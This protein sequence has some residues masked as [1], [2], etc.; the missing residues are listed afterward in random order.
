MIETRW[1][2]FGQELETALTGTKVHIGRQD[3]A[4]FR[5]ERLA[6]EE[7]R[8]RELE[9]VLADLHA[10]LGAERER[11]SA[12][13]ALRDAEDE[14]RQTANLICLLQTNEKMV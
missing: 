4:A 3:R 14:P 7:T 13:K 5:H 12:M 6:I 10:T 1:E 2:D 11:R 9:T 8:R